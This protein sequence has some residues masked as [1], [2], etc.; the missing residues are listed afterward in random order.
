[1]TSEQTQF[2]AIT[3]I[4]IELETVEIVLIDLAEFKY[5][6]HRLVAI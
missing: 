1:M 5:E 6:L 3:T 4:I 2:L